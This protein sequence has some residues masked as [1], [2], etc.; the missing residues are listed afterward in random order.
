MH[1]IPGLLLFF[2]LKYIKIIIYFFKKNILNISISEQSK[3]II[4]SK[5]YLFFK[6]KH[7]IT[8]KTNTILCFWKYDVVECNNF[9]K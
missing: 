5:K 2:I 3:N 9:F 4:Q 8:A 6:K 7:D 1:S